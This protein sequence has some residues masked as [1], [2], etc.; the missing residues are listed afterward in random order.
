MAIEE[1]HCAIRHV[2]LDLSELKKLG[3]SVPL[4]PEN[5]TADQEATIVESYEGGMK[6][7]EISD[8]VIQLASLK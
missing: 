8:L 2:C 7:S 4:D 5:L 1:K 3:V 6:I